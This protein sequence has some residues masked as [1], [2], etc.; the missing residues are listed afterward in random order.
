LRA[1]QVGRAH[2]S[3]RR[4][5]RRNILCICNAAGGDHRHAHG[6]DDPLH[7]GNGAGLGREIVRQEHSAVPPWRHHAP[8][9][10]YGGRAEDAFDVVIPSLPG[11]GF[12]ERPTEAGWELERI[13]SACS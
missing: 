2:L 9:F 7:Q 3:G 8:P 4:Q 5:R 11:F 1:E 10:K 12:S 6:R 13:G